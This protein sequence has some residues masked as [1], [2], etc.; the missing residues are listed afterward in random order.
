MDDGG[1]RPKEVLHLT[2]KPLRMWEPDPQ[3][4]RPRSFPAT[5]FEIV[6]DAQADVIGGCLRTYTVLPQG[7]TVEP[8]VADTIDWLEMLG[9]LL[10][11]DGV[12]ECDKPFEEYL[13]LSGSDPGDSAAHSTI[14]GATSA[15]RDWRLAGRGALRVEGKGRDGLHYYVELEDS[16]VLHLSGYGLRAYEPAEDRAPCV[17]V[18]RLRTPRSPSIVHRMA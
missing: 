10:L 18:R 13:R 5:R 11:T 14:D 1:L 3:T 8:I 6:P 17:P 7:D 9:D 15:H 2:G 12:E 16:T 4:D